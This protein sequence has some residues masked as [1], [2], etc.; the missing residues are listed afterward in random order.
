MAVLPTH[1][2]LKT[3]ALRWFVLV[4]VGVALIAAISPARAHADYK[5]AQ[6]EPDSGY[7]EATWQPFGAYFSIWGR[8]ECGGQTGYGL[9]LDTGSDTAGT[10][11]GA[12]LAWR[13]TAPP[14]TNFTTA[15]ASL[16]YGNDGGFAAAS[17]SDGA[18][19][20]FNVFT[21][22]SR[23]EWA[24]PT[25]GAGGKLFEI[26]L[27]CFASRG[28]HSNWSYAWTTNVLATLHDDAAPAIAADGSLLSG[29][30][31]RGNQ[32]LRATAT[33]VGG[34]A[35][36]IDVYVNGLVS[37]AADFCQPDYQGIRYARLKPCPD[38]WTQQF[39][40]DTQNDPGWT[41]GPNDVV[42][43]ARDV[44]GNASPCIQRTIEVDNSCP[45][46][47]GIAAADLDGGAD[48]GGK[49]TDRA[50]LSSNQEPVI[51]GVLRDGAGGPV[52]GATV[53]IYQTVDLPD[54][55]RELVTAVT[56]QGNGRFATRLDAGPSRDLDLVYRY[57]DRALADGVRVDS[58]VVPTLAIPDKRLA[59]GQAAHFAG[60][61]PGPNADGR[62]VA[63]QARV[64]RKWRTFKQLRTDSDG[65]FHGKYRFTQTIG[66]VRYVFRALVKRQSGYPYE[67]GSSR[68]RELTVHG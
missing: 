6:C 4:A 19:V 10:A 33:D 45:G 31:V 63:L 52:S 28:C 56:T 47:G 30:V 34:G 59:N 18:P 67:P 54:A 48:V 57:N 32:V 61:L 7:T 35:R 37:K 20:T 66:R 39:S 46:S 17:F 53:C 58:T 44:A 2:W 50:A 13:F 60:Q 23:S 29:G 43:C 1:R 68:K 38:S 16:H 40:V 27:Q 22:G 55:S 25:A 3:R 51:R 41:N 42:I 65:R 21:G 5:V 62:A 14:G 36:W 12:G 15:S 49:L 64:G 24:T 9:R 26:R 11:N 8:N